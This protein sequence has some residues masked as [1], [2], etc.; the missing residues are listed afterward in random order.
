MRY[1]LGVAQDTTPDIDALYVVLTGW[2]AAKQVKTYGDL[3]REYQQSHGTWFEPHGTW[4]GPLGDINR[5]L[6]KKRL[7]ALSA[8]VVLAHENRE[9]GG[10]FWGCAPNVPPRPKSD[11]ERLT[12]WSKIVTAVHAMKWP[13]ALPD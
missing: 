5:R 8:L 4:D 1:P 13:S 6:A 12:V 9:P 2:A 10:G 3:S 7:P 11:I